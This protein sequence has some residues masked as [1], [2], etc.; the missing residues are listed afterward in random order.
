VLCTGSSD[1]QDGGEEATVTVR[2]SS[3]WACSGRRASDGDGGTRDISGSD[4]GGSGQD[5]GMRPR[6]QWRGRR[7]QRAL[8]RRQRREEQFLLPSYQWWALLIPAGC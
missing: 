1:L 8:G 6:E 2:L 7:E 3:T 5:D 4:G